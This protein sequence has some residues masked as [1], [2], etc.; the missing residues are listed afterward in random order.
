MKKSNKFNYKYFV[1]EYKGKTIHAIQFI[2]SKYLQIE[3]TT[4]HGALKKLKRF[5]NSLTPINI[6]GYKR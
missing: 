6:I 5:I 4:K 3:S 1:C 2:G